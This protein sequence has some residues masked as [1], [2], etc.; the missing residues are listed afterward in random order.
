MVEKQFVGAIYEVNPSLKEVIKGLEI[1]TSERNFFKK[2]Y[3]LYVEVGNQLEELSEYFKAGS[4]Y[5]RVDALCDVSVF[6]INALRYLEQEAEAN[7]TLDK[8]H[9]VLDYQTSFLKPEA[10]NIFK[11][12]GVLA[13]MESKEYMDVKV[14]QLIVYSR[15][16]LERLGYNYV[17]CMI[18]TIKEIS[19]REQDPAQA[20]SWKV[21][22]VKG[23]WLKNKKQKPETLYKADY[24]ICKKYVD[25]ELFKDEPE[26]NYL[27]AMCNDTRKV[28]D[29][30]SDSYKAVDCPN[31]S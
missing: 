2:P 14:I 19:S 31:C 10:V 26:N 4:D 15:T 27:C 18:E 3:D 24:D 16:I 5:E 30:N 7:G 9:Y 23:K 11:L 20:F 29:Y 21:H 22:G 13:S 6:G 17:D 25:K 28:I 12:I 8:F 1:Y